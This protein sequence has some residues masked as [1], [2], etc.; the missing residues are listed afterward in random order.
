VCFRSPEVAMEQLEK[1]L[2]LPPA[3]VLSS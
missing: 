2:S 1:M 3:S